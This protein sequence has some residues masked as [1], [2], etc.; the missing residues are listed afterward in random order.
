METPITTTATIIAP[1][2][3]I[4]RATLPNGKEVLAHRGKDFTDP[5]EIGNQVTVELTPYD[6]SRAR[7]VAVVK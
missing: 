6:L 7:I 1:F 4:F 3:E 2:S 5:I